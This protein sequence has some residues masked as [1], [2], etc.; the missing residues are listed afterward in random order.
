[1]SMINVRHYILTKNKNVLT[2]G[3]E[4]SETITNTIPIIHYPTYI[5][6]NICIIYLQI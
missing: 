3:Q 4:D 5:C 2:T 6:I 1:M